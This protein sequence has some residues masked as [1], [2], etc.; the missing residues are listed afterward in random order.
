[1]QSHSRRTGRRTDEFPLPGPVLVAGVD[2][3][4]PEAVWV[5]GDVGEVFTVEFVEELVRRASVAVD[6]LQMLNPAL[7]S[8]ESLEA[9]AVGTER[10]RRQ[11]DAAGV[12]IAGHVDTAQPFRGDGFFTAKAWLKHRLQL[13]GVEAYRRV[14]TAR[15]QARLPLWAAGAERW[16]R[17][18]LLSRS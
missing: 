5:G 3:F 10:V 11:V 18:V 9:L 2:E 6:A 14:Q 8:N 13:S 1:M 4:D 17:W 15:M 7:L 16:C 12:G